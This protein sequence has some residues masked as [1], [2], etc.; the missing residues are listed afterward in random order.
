[1][2][3][4]LLSGCAVLTVLATLVMAGPASA[5][6]G[7]ISLAHDDCLEDGG[8]QSKTTDCV[9]NNFSHYLVATF[10]LDGAMTQFVGSEIVLD[11]IDDSSPTDMGAWWQWDAAGCRSGGLAAIFDPSLN[12]GFSAASCEDAFASSNFGPSGAIGLLQRPSSGTALPINSQRIIVGVAVRSDDPVALSS[13]VQ[14]VPVTLRARATTAQ[15][16][17]CTGC[18]NSIVMSVNSMLVAQLPGAPGGDATISTPNP[19]LA[20]GACVTYNQASTVCAAGTTP[21]E[22]KTWGQVKSLYR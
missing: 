2:R 4:S 6:N 15:T 9:T 22:P 14:Y 8:T 19:F 16:A 7:T 17:A 18:G 10:E 5:I 20:N 13:G 21:A 11:M 1:M 3:N 12:P